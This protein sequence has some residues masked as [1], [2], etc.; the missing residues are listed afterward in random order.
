ML[1]GLFDLI[2]KER[3]EN[4]KKYSRILRSINIKPSSK[5]GQNFLIDEKLVDAQ[6]KFAK[7]C[8]TDTVLEIGPGLG[9]LT[10][11]LASKANKVIAIEFDRSLYSYLKTEVPSNVELLF[12]DAVKLDLPNFNK[13]VSNIPYQISSPIIFKLINHEFDIAVLMLQLEFA[14]RLTGR[15]NT[16]QYSRLTVM[17]SYYYTT[18]LLINVSKINFMP[19][20]KVDSAIVRLR[21]KTEKRTAKNEDLFSSLV[22]VIFQ[23]RRK[24]I[25]NSISN[26]HSQLNIPRATL[27]SIITKLPHMESRPEQLDLDQIIELSD[28]LDEALVDVDD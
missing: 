4:K 11:K 25:K 26:N 1:V 27:K 14:K 17:S 3:E 6:I 13:I 15:P 16:K 28:L 7:I 8:D 21:P 22:K 9:I 19:P 20:P 23:G 24:M 18:E 10:N 12:G 5:L 2:N